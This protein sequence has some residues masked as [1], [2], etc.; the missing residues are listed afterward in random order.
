MTPDYEK[1]IEISVASAQKEMIAPAM[2][3]M[4]SPVVV[5]LFI[6]VDAVLGLLVGST[7]VGFLTAIKMAN[8]GGAFD[9]AKKYIEDGMH[10]GKGSAAHK[11][12]VVCDTVGDPLK[13]TAGPSINILIKLMSMVALVSAHMVI[14]LNF[15]WF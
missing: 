12:A 4:L 13:D 15:G 6:G 11:V 2:I 1:C 9:N 7:L 3:A 8:V 10:G 5:G 14:A